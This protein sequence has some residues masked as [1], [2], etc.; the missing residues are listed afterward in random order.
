M[1]ADGDFDYA[2]LYELLASYKD[3]KRLKI[4]S[5]C[6]GSNITGNYFDTD[7]ISILCH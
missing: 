5:F 6:A 4:G 3:E 7:R 1:T 2:H